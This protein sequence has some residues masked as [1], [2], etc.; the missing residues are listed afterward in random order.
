MLSFRDLSVA[1]QQA[2]QRARLQAERAAA[3][4]FDEEQAWF[5]KKISPDE[6]LRRKVA[7]DFKSQTGQDPLH[8]S[9]KAAHQDDPYK[10]RVAW[11]VQPQF[12]E[13]NATDVVVV[14]P[15]GQRFNNTQFHPGTDFRNRRG[16]PAFSPKNGTI[17]AIS[18]SPRGG[19]EVFILLD[20]GSIVSYAH[21]GILDDGQGRKLMVG[22]EVYA[23]QLI[24]WSDG[25]GV[26]GD[27][28]PNDPHTHISY[29]PP[30]T[31]VHPTKK[32]PLQGAASHSPTTTARTQS[33]PFDA[34]DYRRRP[35]V[36]N[37]D[38]YTG[39]QP[40]REER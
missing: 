1:R 22:D 38:G 23:G 4:T 25:S 39:K 16:R 7:A 35:R 24:G 37:R 26:K 20:D 12:Q 34:L 18:N 5:G 31:P 19:N 10:D 40:Q 14:S 3:D 11:P 36:L 30:G 27:G 28:T 15:W 32:T 29:Y 9:P 8:F 33:D 21:T 13:N 6:E 2:Q 17:L